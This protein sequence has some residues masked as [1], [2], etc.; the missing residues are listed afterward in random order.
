M[1]ETPHTIAFAHSWSKKMTVEEKRELERLIKDLQR[2]AKSLKKRK[3]VG[4]AVFAA[5][6]GDASVRGDGNA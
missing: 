5:M 2:N 6:R 3:T 4:Q 1:T